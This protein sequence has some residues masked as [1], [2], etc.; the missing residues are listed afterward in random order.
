MNVPRDEVPR[1][2]R[3]GKFV[4]K[5]R[6]EAQLVSSG[7]ASVGR[8]DVRTPVYNSNSDSSLRSWSETNAARTKSGC[9][10]CVWIF[11]SVIPK[12]CNEIQIE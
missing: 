10:T 5:L 3:P 9:V 4:S 6:A 12:P 2:T 8:E 1:S 11:R 7:I